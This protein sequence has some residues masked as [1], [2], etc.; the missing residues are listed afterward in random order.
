MN[1]DQKRK[2]ISK[3]DKQ[4]KPDKC[5][6]DEDVRGLLCSDYQKTLTAILFGRKERSLGRVDWRSERDWKG[7]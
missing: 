2:Y 1:V 3:I 6:N 5:K 7:K 4:L